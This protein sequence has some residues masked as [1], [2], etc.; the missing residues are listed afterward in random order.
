MLAA[1]V[2]AAALGP[3][4]PLTTFN[5]YDLRGDFTVAGVGLRNTGVGSVFLGLPAGATVVQALLYWAV[6]DDDAPPPTA[7]LN[8]SAL[9]GTLVAQAGD[10]CW[11]DLNTA[12]ADPATVFTWVFRADVTA[13]AISGPN[14]VSGVPSKL[15]GGEPPLVPEANRSA[16]PLADGA[17][18][19]VVYEDATANARTIVIREGGETVFDG[20]ASTTFDLPALGD[21]TQARTAFIVAD[22]QSAFAGDVARFNDVPVAGPGATLRPTDAFNGTDGGG[23]AVAHGLWDT[24]V[25]DVGPLMAAGTRSATATV[26][27]GSG[28]DCL[29][30]VAQ[31][32]SWG[33]VPPTTTTT[34]STTSTSIEPASTTTT[35][36]PGATTT[37]TSTIDGATTTTTS[38]IVTTSTTTK[39]TTSI[40]DTPSSNN[41]NT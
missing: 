2:Q 15:T 28:F 35:S 19:V 11:P 16:F 7:T 34:S 31:V 3:R 26:T 29:T 14:L 9:T 10:P 24:L 8:G 17:A 5:T 25:A 38:R 37:T 4:V 30:W 18:L 41:L 23:P 36:T 12:L 20:S 22:G 27:S 39:T 40:N 13:Q 6:I 1:S 21:L 33:A 32:L